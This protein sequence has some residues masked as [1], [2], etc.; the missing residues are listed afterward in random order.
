MTFQG[1]MARKP[2]NFQHTQP[3]TN[4]CISAKRFQIA[5]FTGIVKY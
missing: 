3:A 2:N 4:E 1:T 5:A